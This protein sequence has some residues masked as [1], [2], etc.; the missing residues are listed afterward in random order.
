MIIPSGLQSTT[1]GMELKVQGLT[2]K[3]LKINDEM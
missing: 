1:L 3:I 2:C